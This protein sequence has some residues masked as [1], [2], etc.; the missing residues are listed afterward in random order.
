MTRP[1][2]TKILQLATL[3]MPEVIEG[4]HDGRAKFPCGDNRSDDYHHG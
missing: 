4:Y 2:I 1:L 3:D